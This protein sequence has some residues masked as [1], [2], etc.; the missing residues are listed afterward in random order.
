M[1]RTYTASL[2]FNSDKDD[3]ASSRMTSTAAVVGDMAHYA[4]LVNTVLFAG[5]VALYM[6]VDDN[7]V[8]SSSM[9]KANVTNHP[10]NILDDVW[11]EQGFCVAHA[12][13]PYFTSHDV[14]LYADV[15]AAAILAVVYYMLHRTPGMELA[16]PLLAT[17]I[18]GII[19]HGIGHGALAAGNRSGVV[20]ADDAARTG[21]EILTKL[22]QTDDNQMKAILTQ[23]VPL[24]F[25]WITLIKASL[26]NVKTVTVAVVVMA[27]Q[28][29]QL[30]VP[31]QFGFT[32]VQTVL[33]LAFSLNQL[34]RPVQEKDF[35]YAM[36]AAVVGLPVTMVGWMESTQCSAFVMDYLY[37]HVVYDVYI[38]CSMLVWYLTCYH[39]AVRANETSSSTSG[40]DKKKKTV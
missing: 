38:P 7:G 30:L 16:N 4:I 10:T 22:W 26:P 3:K 12:D 23:I 15:A 25:F 27:A 8:D 36:Y 1:F 32:Y 20:A 37:G 21:M 33:M 5:T 14:C 19:G 40:M 35:S 11:K 13:E 17:G 6:N 18:P 34:N 2:S 39:R 28:F 9:M 29:F 31:N 24:T